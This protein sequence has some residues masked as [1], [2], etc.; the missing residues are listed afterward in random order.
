MFMATKEE[1]KL[2]QEAQVYQQQ[3]QIITN[4]KEALGLQ[5]K[6]IEKAKE[7]MGKVKDEDVYKI[8]GPILIK[9]KKADVEKDLLEKEEFIKTRVKTIEKSEQKIREKMSELVKGGRKEEK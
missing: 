5:M 8:A 6:E 1:L 4:Q 3:L 7:E 9:S 2:L